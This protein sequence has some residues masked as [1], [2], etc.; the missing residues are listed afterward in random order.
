MDRMSDYEI[1]YLRHF[2]DQKTV[3]E[4]PDGFAE[5]LFGNGDNC[6]Y[7]RLTGRFVAVKE[8]A[9]QGARTRYCSGI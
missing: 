6:Y 7:D 1:S 4:F 2:V 5:M 9:F 3:R 8:G